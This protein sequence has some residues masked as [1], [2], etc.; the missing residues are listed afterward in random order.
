MTNAIKF[1]RKGSI[2]VQARVEPDIR[3]ADLLM[4]IVSVTDQGVGMDSEEAAKVFDGC[5]DN[6]SPLSKSLNPYGNGIGLSFCKKVCQSFDGNITV[7]TA[8]GQGSSFE[9]TMRVKKVLNVMG[10]EISRAKY[11]VNSGEANQ[12]EI[13][14]QGSCMNH[15][16]SIDDLF[17][18]DLE[19]LPLS[20]QEQ[21]INFQ[22]ANFYFK[23]SRTVPIEVQRGDPLPQFN[24]L[25]RFL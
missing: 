10:N 3:N 8:L 24:N 23:F 12:S 2:F 7:D 13:L 19:Q 15:D 1:T 21:I 4:L 17:E 22:G 5:F 9:F 11:E 25:I 16:P 14:V 20:K 18:E 6:R